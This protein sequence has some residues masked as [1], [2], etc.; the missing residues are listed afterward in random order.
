MV[1]RTHGAKEY[2]KGNKG[3]CSDLVDYLGKENEG[4]ELT[5]Q[6]HF[7]NKE[8]KYI[9]DMAVTE[10]IDHNVK[11]LK[12]KDTKFFMLS[13]NPSQRELSHL[14]N[15][16][17]GRKINDI[18][19]MNAKELE[20]YNGMLKEYTNN[21]MEL[22]AARFNR[23]LTADNIL[24]FAKVEQE[25][26]Y[27]YK[28]ES[29]SRAVQYM[30]DEGKDYPTILKELNNQRP[31]DIKLFYDKGVVHE[32]DKKAGLQTHV[33][34]VV[35]RMDKDMKTS[36]SPLANPRN[37]KVKLNGKEHQVG[38]DRDQFK[39][40]TE[41]LF[42]KQ[43]SYQREQGEYYSYAKGNHKTTNLSASQINNFVRNY[44]DKTQNSAM[45]QKDLGDRES[46]K[47]VQLAQSFARKDPKN[48]VQGILKMGQSELNPG[49]LG[50]MNHGEFLR[51][52]ASIA[53]GNPISIAKAALQVV[54]STISIE[55]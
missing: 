36:I 33:H 41:T 4:L 45:N 16:A 50:R 31:A 34:I 2:V 25:R 13:V 9:N 47:G 8:S 53:K 49:D 52:A 1:V 28:D 14:A 11:G 39:Q 44:S 37:S 26:H 17:C 32:G 23:N 15:L 3:S 24:Y 6:E 12:S 35:S 29:L 5:K 19:E 55:I 21:V 40:D 48:A 20:K 46:M 7:F 22:Y 27:T 51:F 18:S 38:F 10:R 54:K 30:K 42:D 43:F